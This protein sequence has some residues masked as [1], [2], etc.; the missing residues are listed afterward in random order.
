MFVEGSG[1]RAPETPPKVKMTREEYDALRME[2][3][4]V[5]LEIE[6]E[7]RRIQALLM[8]E[9]RGKDEGR[10]PA[11]DVAIIEA[12]GLVRDFRQLREF[13]RKV[14]NAVIV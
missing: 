14:A 8:S 7:L 6:K 13:Y 4:R 5:W 10:V 2:S 9:V 11:C 1:G 12:E 3:G